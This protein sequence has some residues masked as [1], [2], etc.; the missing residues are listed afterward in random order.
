MIPELRNLNYERRLQR[1]ELISLEQRRLRGQL[2]ET[3]K[4]LNGLNNDTLEGLFERDGNDFLRI[5]LLPTILSYDAE[6]PVRK[7][8]LRCSAHFIVHHIETKTYCVV[9]SIEQ[10]TSTIWKFNGDDK[11]EMTEEREERFIQVRA[12]KF[13]LQLFSPVNWQMIPNTDHELEKWEHVTACKNVSLAY[14]GD[15]SGLRGYICVAT[16]YTYGEDITCRGRIQLFDVIDVVPEPGQPLTKNKLKL[17]YDQEQKGPVTNIAHCCGNLVTAIGQKMYIWTL[18][19]NQDLVGVAFIDT[20]IYIHR[21]IPLKTLILAADVC[22]SVSV[23]RFEQKNRTISLVSKDLKLM[24]VYS[25]EYL[26]DG[27]K[28]AFVASDSD[29]NIVVL[30]YSPENRESCGGTR[31]VRKGDFNLGSHVNTF[32]RCVLGACDVDEWLFLGVRVIFLRIRCRITDTAKASEEIPTP[33]RHVTVMATLDG[34]LAYLLP[35]SERFYKRFSAVYTVLIHQLPHYAGLNPKACRTF[36]TR[37]K[38]LF[39]PVRGI[40]DGNLLF[41]FLHLPLPEKREVAKK[42]GTSVDEIINEL[43]EVD[44]CTAHF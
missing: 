28:L 1:L 5:C 35:V 16:I 11:E 34:S 22:K 23:M 30:K 13:S 36:R 20:G 15:R 12:P 3:F 25:T 24:Q 31:L 18:R 29:K 37:R 40:L 2:I 4:Y 14:E 33:H 21:L 41:Q 39:N 7:V 9:T 32:F 10:P 19:N 27:N 6:W 8:P 42:A 43:R 38:I 26:V 17:L 44:R